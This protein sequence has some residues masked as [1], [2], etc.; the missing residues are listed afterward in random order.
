MS[1]AEG[2][3]HC[4][5]CNESKP[6]DLF[7]IHKSGKHIGL[8]YGWCKPCQSEYKKDRYRNEPGYRETSLKQSNEWAAAN[9]ERHA[10]LGAKWKRKN[11]TR[12]R[13]VNLA[14][15]HT[16]GKFKQ[17]ERRRNEQLRKTR[18]LSARSQ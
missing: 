16:K 3:R 13:A 7:Y 10:E 5:H 15:W 8:H 2:T 9:P 4:V 12:T 6:Y 17:Q 18:M 14:H 11:A 1:T